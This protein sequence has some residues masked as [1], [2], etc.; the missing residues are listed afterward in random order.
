MII[1]Y[2]L[3][4]CKVLNAKKIKKQQETSQK[5][6]IEVCNGKSYI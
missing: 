1:T 5:T 6:C 2:F 4:K 3:S